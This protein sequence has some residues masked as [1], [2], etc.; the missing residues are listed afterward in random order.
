M[1]LKLVHVYVYLIHPFYQII[2]C[3]VSEVLC[4]ST[5]PYL[6]IEILISQVEC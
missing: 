4:L 3:I 1:Y 6:S 5:I 2:T